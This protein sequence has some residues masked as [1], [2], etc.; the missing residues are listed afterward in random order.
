MA[1]EYRR[2]GF[3]LMRHLFPR[4]MTDRFLAEIHAVFRR[5]MQAAGHGFDEDAS[6]LLT[7]DSL[8]RFFER[9]QSAYVACMKAVQNLLV[10]FEFATHAPLIEAVRD[11]GVRS[12][13]FST[14]PIVMIS[15]P[16]TAASYAYWKTPPHQDW[17]SIQGSLNGIVVWAA[18]V[19]IVP[20]IGPLEVIPGSHLWG[21]LPSVKDEWYRRID[22]PRVTDEAFVSVPMNAGDTLLFSSF[23]VHRSGH[24]DGSRARF[25]L[26]ARFNDMAE[27]EFVRRGYPSTYASD[28]PVAD[29]VED[30]RGPG[31]EDVASAIGIATAPST[32]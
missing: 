1:T 5:H 26:Q 8:H 6:G 31:P 15:N 4:A 24:S 18:L 20:A 16:R 14:K 2:N 19:D 13:A 3:C 12:P 7:P 9:Q 29:F 22:D 11:L 23:L 25:S 10:S 32:E 17:R 27:P 30:G 21:L 28:T